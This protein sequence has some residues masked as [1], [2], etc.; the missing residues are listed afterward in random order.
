MAVTKLQRNA[1]S[2]LARY[3]DIRAVGPLTEA[4]DYRDRGLADAAVPKLAEFLP[5]LQSGDAALLDDAQRRILDR[6][7]L[8][9]RKPDLVLAILAAYEQVGDAKSLEA[10]ERL[11]A[12]EGRCAKDRRVREAAIDCH[13]A[14]KQR[15]QAERD[16]QTLLR[17]VY[18]GDPEGTL[19]R[20]AHGPGDADA[21]V[22]LRPAME[23]AGGMHA[24]GSRT[25]DQPAVHTEAEQV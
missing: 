3:D 25:E 19:L 21:K 2:A 14:L 8:K 24:R 18:T 15:A 7:L 5:R 4:L 11:A 10:V 6:V 12:G 13:A 17:P 16:A 9:H 1:I 20:P 23:P 22:L